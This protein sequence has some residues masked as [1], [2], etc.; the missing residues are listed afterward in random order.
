MS[1]ADAPDVG[2]GES[3]EKWWD[4]GLTEQEKRDQLLGAALRL[5][6][7]I[8]DPLDEAQPS[9][10]APPPDDAEAESE[11]VC[12]F[13]LPPDGRPRGERE[14]RGAWVETEEPKE[15]AWDVSD[16][17]A[18]RRP[19]SDSWELLIAEPAPRSAMAVLESCGAM[20][21]SHLAHVCVWPEHRRNER[22]RV[23]DYSYYTLSFCP[24]PNVELYLQLWSEPDEQTAICEVS[25]GAKDGSVADYLDFSKH[26]LLRD[27]GFEIGGGG[28]NFRKIVSFTNWDNAHSV[29]R[30]VIAILCNVLGYDGT[31]DLNYKLSLQTP[32]YQRL[33][34]SELSPDT[35]R[36][37]MNEWGFSAELKTDEKSRPVVRARNG[38]FAVFLLDESKVGSRRYRRLRLTAYP[39]QKLSSDSPQELVIKINRGLP[40]T[41]SCDKDGDLLVT[42]DVFLHGGVT[43]DHLR[44]RIELWR[45]ALDAIK[46]G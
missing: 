40:L 19:F 22:W 13:P 36:K 1:T 4:E 21:A 41:A 34:L 29:A 23:G 25:S 30:E 9:G 10:S 27:H 6:L 44:D 11:E 28:A 37:L 26:E 32:Y 14:R 39:K 5:R 16:L 20:L 35:L 43:L 17:S 42:S 46:Q 8:R 33:V 24:K 3:G 15:P 31:V 45:W 18:A 2:S 7:G 12:V 38:A